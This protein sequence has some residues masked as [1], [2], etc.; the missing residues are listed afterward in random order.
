MDQKLNLEGL[1]PAMFQAKEKEPDYEKVPQRKNIFLTWFFSVI[2]FGVYSSFWFMKR[3]KEFR[4]LGTSKK[5]QPS[6][7]TSL[8]V[9]NI[10]FLAS[11]LVFPLTI[12][13]DMG[14]LFGNM[15]TMQT[16]NLFLIGAFSLLYVFFS[17]LNAF[18]SRSVINQALE[19]KESR[20]RVSVFFT[21][22]FSHVYLQYEI[23]KILLD[24]EDTP[25]KGPW[26]FFLLIVILIIVG[27]VY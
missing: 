18:Y 4:N 16:A 10:F 13:Q 14:N 24:K 20:S 12:T 23:N 8:A 11:V 22:I 25:K 27:I 26:F 2:T 9:F 6:I 7:P 19:S 5:I 17:L 1:S 3:A 21:L 15:T